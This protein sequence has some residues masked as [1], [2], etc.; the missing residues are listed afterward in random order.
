M[1]LVIGGA[2]QGKKEYAEERWKVSDWCDGR[3]CDREALFSAEAAEHLE[4]LIHRELEEDR[5][6][7]EFCEELLSK[8]PD[9]IL[10]SDEIGYG[11]VPMEAFERAYRECT[12]R[13]LTKLAKEARQVHRVVCGIGTVIKG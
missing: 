13:I 4:R 5:E 6:P 2:N 8:N 9:I 11:L 3:T 10:V 1:I 12:G 7:E